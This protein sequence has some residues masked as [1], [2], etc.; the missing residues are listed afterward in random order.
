[1]LGD[2]RVLIAGGD[3]GLTSVEFYNSFI[4]IWIRNGSMNERRSKYT[5]SVFW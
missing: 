1:M 4:E 5:A 2:G 3:G